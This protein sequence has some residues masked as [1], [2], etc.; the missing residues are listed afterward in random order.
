MNSQHSLLQ[1]RQ[2]LYGRLTGN[3]AVPN[4]DGVFVN[5]N[6]AISWSSRTTSDV[7]GKKRREDSHIFLLV[8]FIHH[9]IANRRKAS[10]FLLK[11]VK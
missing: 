1:C 10:W 4:K 2:I 8:L 7:P 6:L 11:D 9:T 3:S 5:L